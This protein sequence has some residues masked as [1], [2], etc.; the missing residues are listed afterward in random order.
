MSATGVRATGLPDRTQVGIIGAGPAGL[1][2]S[3]LLHLHGISSVVLEARDRPYVEHRVRA[4]VLEQGSVDILREAGLAER[5]DREGLV[6]EG[7]ELRFDG[8]GHRVPMTELTGRAIT[9]YGQ[10]EVVKDL[11]ARRL[12]DGGDLRFEV[13]DVTL[14]GLS[15]DRPRIGY[16]HEGRRRELACDVVAGCDG[17][18]GISRPAVMDHGLTMYERE[19]PFAWLGILVHAAPAVDELI[20]ANH[21]DGFA[22]YSMRSPAIS[23]LYLQVDADADLEAWSDDRIWSALATRFSLDGKPWEP[24]R[25]EIIEKG[26]T[27]MRS[28]V[29]EPMQHGRLLLAGDAVHIVPPTG[30]KGMNL[31]IHDVWLMARALDAW[32]NG[33]D[34]RLVADYT[35]DALSR[36]W[37]AQHF[38]WWMTSM[39][40]RFP[41][42]DTFQHRVQLA[43]LANVVSSSAYSTALAENYVG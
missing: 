28:V 27:P 21:E 31:A 6:H 19:Y 23:R 4:G 42:D 33:Q 34:D 35:R 20:Y 25:G 13:S 41:G 39:L 9:V 36:V 11:V 5:L 2:L 26:I 29:T 30:A 18:H 37:R 14:D 43:Q 22:L 8:A 40:H 12:E 1:L 38:S 24:N 10:Q 32:L 15:G 3:H 7:I 16:V 17:F